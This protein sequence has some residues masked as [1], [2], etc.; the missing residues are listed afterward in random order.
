LVS[1]S[2]VID[3]FDLGSNDFGRVNSPDGG[4]CEAPRREIRSGIANAGD[5]KSLAPT[6]W[7]WLNVLGHRDLSALW[8]TAGGCMVASTRLL[9]RSG[10]ALGSLIAFCGTGF[11]AD[12]VVGMPN[13][14]SG[15]ASANII[16][17]G[18]EKK[19]GLDVEVRE[20]GTLTIFA[21]LDAGQVD[22]HPEV[23][24]PNLDSVVKKYVDERKSVQLSP[25]KVGDTGALRD[26]RNR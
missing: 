14:P 5:E 25:K 23:W 16:K 2:S 11:A 10:V 4:C 19:L 17:Y 6:P 18:I 20:M 9:W 22:V 7:L 8:A 21:G 12:L 3:D 24:Q 13:W 15:Q 26:S 1:T